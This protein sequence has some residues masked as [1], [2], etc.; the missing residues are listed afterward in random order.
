MKYN[1]M[2]LCSYILLSALMA[3]PCNVHSQEFSIPLNQRTQQLFEQL[4]DID[5]LQRNIAQCYQAE[6]K[7]FMV[8]SLARQS[9]GEAAELD[10]K[11]LDRVFRR[12]AGAPEYEKFTVAYQAVIQRP[13]YNKLYATELFG[14][15][16]RLLDSARTRLTVELKQ[17]AAG[18]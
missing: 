8:A 15:Y 10:D 11:L 14:E 1:A 9:V 17:K 13:D 5:L 3:F 6:N 12:L 16:M 2:F 7:T 18:S 4:Q